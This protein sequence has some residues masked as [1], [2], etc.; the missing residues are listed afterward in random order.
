MKLVWV[1]HRYPPVHN[2]GAETYAHQVNL[3][4]Q[5]RGH[6]V[7]VLAASAGI[8]QGV[9]VRSHDSNVAVVEREIRDADVVV[10]H[11]DMTRTAEHA[12]RRAG[13]PLVH[14][15]HNDRQLEHNK[16]EKAEL[17]VSNSKWIADTTPARLKDRRSVV[18]Y[19]PTFTADWSSSGDAVTLVNLMEKKGAPLFYQLAGRLSDRRFLAVTGAYGKQVRPPRLP[20]MT[21]LAN[22]PDMRPVWEQTRILVA[23]SE[24]ES[25]GKAACEAMAAAIPVVAHPTEGLVESLGP[26][27]I[28]CDRANPDEWEMAIRELDDPD[29]YEEAS[30]AAKARAVELETRTIR[31]LVLLERLLVEVAGAD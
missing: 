26:A 16:V 30:T 18:L 1:V 3:W 2:A 17:I 4:L 27:G 12:A 11:L 15:V 20:N 19:P 23:P 28:F 14:V 31:Q 29:R 9:T 10:T 13:K 7:V 22:R 5:E 21:R 25:W 24:Y 8:W 6:R